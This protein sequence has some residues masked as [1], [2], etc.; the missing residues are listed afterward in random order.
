MSWDSAAATLAPLQ[1]L[2]DRAL[3]LEKERLLRTA[4]RSEETLRALHPAVAAAAAGSLQQLR[5]SIHNVRGS[6][7]D[8]S[9]Y[10]EDADILRPRYPKG[11][12]RRRFVQTR[13]VS[14]STF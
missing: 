3:E 4:S 6:S 11:I 1:L 10:R 13:P 9:P 14:G 2:V 12:Y 8:E 7:S 5:L